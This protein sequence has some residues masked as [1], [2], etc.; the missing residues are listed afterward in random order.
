M[1]IALFTECYRPIV[2]GVVVS[3][4]TFAGELTKLGHE[5]DIYAPAYPGHRDTQPNV[6]RLASIS[7]PTRPRYPI[8]LPYSGRL[9]R[10]L[11]LIEGSLPMWVTCNLVYHVSPY[12]FLSL[13]PEPH[14]INGRLPPAESVLSLTK[15]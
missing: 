9:M 13:F 4:E 11:F 7:P 5:V 15:G 6:H 12:G 8:A 2:N 10:R 1:R 3:V 14:Y